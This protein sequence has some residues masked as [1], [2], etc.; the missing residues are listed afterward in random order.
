MDIGKVHRI[1]NSILTGINSNRP[2]EMGK[3]FQLSN[4]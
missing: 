2:S 1:G 4:T 3:V